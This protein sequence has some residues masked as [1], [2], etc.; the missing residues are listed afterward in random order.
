MFHALSSERI[1]TSNVEVPPLASSGV[2]R[3]RHRLDKCVRI[4]FQND[5]ILESPGLGFVGI[6]D[7]IARL[8]IDAYGIPFLSG[9]KCGTATPDQLGSSDFAN[10]AGRSNFKRSTQSLKSA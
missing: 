2:G 9:G 3:D 1:L 7:K 6:A 10:D 8:R 5:A 4:A